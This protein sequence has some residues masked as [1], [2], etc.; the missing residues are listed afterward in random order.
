MNGR[1]RHEKGNRYEVQTAKKLSS[2]TGEQVMRS[3]TSGAGGSRT[4]QEQ[5]QMI[6][7]LF[8]PLKKK[9][10]IVDNNFTYECKCHKSSKL[11]HLFN[12]NGEIPSFWEQATTDCRRISKH[13]PMLIMHVDR[14]DD[15]I[16]VPYNTLFE[17]YLFDNNLPY[18]SK[19]LS[20]TIKMTKQTYNYKVII[21]NLKSLMTTDPNWFYK[22]YEN[23]D[24]DNLNHFEENPKQEINDAMSAI[25]A[26]LNI[27]K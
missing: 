14:E 25:D 8:F 20:Y 27:G 22:I 17:D 13:N 23:C 26:S 16:V 18:M 15:Y 7:D 12:C 6:G 11:V 1:N 10:L 3:L 21:T 9:K 19:K 2:W 4:G 5:A 24:W